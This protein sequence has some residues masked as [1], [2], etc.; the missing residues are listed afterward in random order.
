MVSNKVAEPV[1][2]S[3]EEEKEKEEEVLRNTLSPRV[4]SI[5]EER[6]VFPSLK[7]FEK[8]FV[9]NVLACPM[10]QDC[11]NDLLSGRQKRGK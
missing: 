1:E 4:K 8:M 10:V 11:F 5:E 7:A 2:Y 9:T 3:E 6:G